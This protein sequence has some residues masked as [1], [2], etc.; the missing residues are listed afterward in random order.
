MSSA[1]ANL[2]TA[3]VALL[4]VLLVCAG[5]GRQSTGEDSS[6]PK[7]PQ[8]SYETRGVTVVDDPETLQQAVEDMHERT[9]RP[10]MGMEYKNDAFSE[11]GVDFACYIANA[12]R[13]EYDMFIAIFSDDAL[14]DELFLSGLLRPGTAFEAI[15]LE[16]ALP[17]GDHEV[18]VAFTQV[19][20][21]DGEWVIQGQVIVTM[22]FHVSALP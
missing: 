19:R 14:T 2:P 13:N 20:D 3:V 18:Y 9:N 7:R 21:V 11:N 6:A 1:V 8:L 12:A 16:R 15:S 17:Q 22:D 4:A 5:C 10:A